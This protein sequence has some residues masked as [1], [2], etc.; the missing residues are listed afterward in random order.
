MSLREHL[1]RAVADSRASGRAPKS[2][3]RRG[4]RKYHRPAEAIYA[5]LRRRQAAS[6]VLNAK[7]RELMANS[8]SVAS[9]NLNGT[10][11]ACYQKCGGD[12]EHDSPAQIANTLAA[13]LEH[14]SFNTLL[15]YLTGLKRVCADLRHDQPF[16]NEIVQKVIRGAMREREPSHKMDVLRLT[17]IRQMLK[18]IDDD[19]LQRFEEVR[20]RALLLCC[21]NGALRGGEACRMTIE[22]TH[23]DAQGRVTIF[24]STKTSGG[25][26]VKIHLLDF[27]QQEYPLVQALL[28]WFEISGIGN[29]ALW[30]RIKVGPR[31]CDQRLGKALSHKEI[32]Q[33]IKRRAKAIGMQPENITVHSIRAGVVTSL[34]DQGESALTIGKITRQKDP[35]TISEYYRPDISDISR[36]IS[37]EQ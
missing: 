32:N 14:V 34:A 4:R 24:L 26:V 35:K 10:A 29:G 25:Q 3:R 28:Q 11:V 7:A 8:I 19:P 15:C 33:I 31:G 20:D 6:G 16:E 12:L 9:Q 21:A 5:A 18:K 23:I 13:M 17:S 2:N 27:W 22:N 1:E 37:D 30:R 36:V